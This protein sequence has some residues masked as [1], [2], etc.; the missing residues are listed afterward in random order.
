MHTFSELINRPTLFADRNVLSPHY[1]PE[2]LPHRDKEI[3]KLMANLYPVLK[4]ERPHNTFLYGKT[5]TGKTCC[6]KHVL[7][8]L[9]E[10]KSSCKTCYVNCRMHNSRY[11]VIQKM[12]KELLPEL[13]SMGFGL[14]MLHEKVMGA[15]QA[16]GI[17][18]IAVLDEVDMVKDLDDLLYTLTR[19]NDELTSGSISVI[20]ISNRLSFKDQLDPR[21]KSSLCEN[22]MVFPPYTAVQL[23]AILK[24]RAKTG[25]KPHSIDDGAINLASAI[26]ASETGDARYALKLIMKAAEIT[27]EKG[28]SKITDHEVEEARRSVDKDVA[29]E[30]IS[31]LP[32]H[33]QI[34]LLAIANLTIDK[35]KNTRLTS[36]SQGEEESFI[37]SGEAYEEYSKTA[38]KF[39]KPVR[40][41]RWFRE[42]INDLEMLGL[43]TTL[44]SGSGMR[45]RT[46]L[47]K[48]GH[49]ALDVQKIIMKNFSIIEGKN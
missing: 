7:S 2:T 6:V 38:K 28:A 29:F 32:D 21:S 19:A 26:T 43:I 15:V 46:R 44:E 11:R 34:V 49:T 20:G 9:S 47:I 1:I 25:F 3:E 14:A 18:I 23:Q 13:D 39:R 48:I 16:G 33:Q 5:G 41:A 27:D 24:Q 10:H 35:G 22:E 45:G 30:A 8:K 37:T 12:A 31:T 17:H 4:N 42:Y 36:G 40:S